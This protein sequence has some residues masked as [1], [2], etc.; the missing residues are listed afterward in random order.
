MIPLKKKN[1]K[2]RYV[3]VAGNYQAGI[4]VVD[5][6]D[7]ANAKEIAYADP[8]PLVPEAD[9]GDWST[10]WYNGRIYESDIQRGLIIW[11][12]DDDRVGTYLR[13]PYSNPQ[14]QEYLIDR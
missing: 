6:S 3:L 8:P 7:P 13:M 14:T 4:S 11:R 9:Y 5:F 10:Y 2:P 1:G 12:L